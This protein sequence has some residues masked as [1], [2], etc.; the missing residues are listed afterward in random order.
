M[1]GR[2]NAC[3]LALDPGVV[4]GHERQYLYWHPCEM[5]KGGRLLLMRYVLHSV[6]GVCYQERRPRLVGPFARLAGAALVFAFG[7]GD[8]RMSS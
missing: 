1:D 5:R 8:G 6:L 4:V 2:M 3:L 7:Y